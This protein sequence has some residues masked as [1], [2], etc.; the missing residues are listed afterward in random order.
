MGILNSKKLEEAKKIIRS[1]TAKDLQDWI[2]SYNERIA[3][4]EQADSILQPAVIKPRMSTAKLNG[5]PQSAPKAKGI[6]IKK[7]NAKAPQPRS[8]D[9]RFASA[10]KTTKREAAFA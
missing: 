8:S 7:M 5:A 2:D 1:H 10:K 3:L 6:P 9:G 4:A